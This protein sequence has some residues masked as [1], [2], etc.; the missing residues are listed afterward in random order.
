MRKKGRTF[1]IQGENFIAFGDGRLL[2]CQGRSHPGTVNGASLNGFRDESRTGR[3][4]GG[5]P[6]E[7]MNCIG[8]VESGIAVEHPHHQLLSLYRICTNSAFLIPVTNKTRKPPHISHSS[9]AT[10]LYYIFFCFFIAKLPSCISLHSFFFY[11]STLLSVSLPNTHD[12]SIKT[13]LSVLEE[14]FMFPNQMAIFLSSLYSVPQQ[15]LKQLTCYLDPKVNLVPSGDLGVRNSNHPG[16]S[17]Q[18]M[19]VRNE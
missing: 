2:K 17:L 19:E 9:L 15:Y 5:G 12:H 7:V 18:Q 4:Q 6:G 13:S 1:I 8:N 11:F 14:A 3:L 16:S 10:S